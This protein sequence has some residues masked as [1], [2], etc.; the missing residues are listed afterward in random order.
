MP[1]VVTG[2][3]VAVIGLNL[4]PIAV[5]G[6]AGS[7]LRHVD[8]HR[9]DRR[10]GP[11][12]RARAGPRAPAADPARRARR[13]RC[14]T[15]CS[16]TASGSASRSTSP[17]SPA[18]RGSACRTFTAPVWN[19]QAMALIAPVAIVLVAENLGHVKAVAAMTGQNLDPYLGRAFVGD[20]IA[21][22]V[23]GARRRHR[24]HDLRREHRRHGGHEDLLDARVRRRGAHRDRARLLAQVRRADHDDSRPGA[25]RARRS[26]C[27]A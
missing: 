16:P 1:P 7:A 10:R 21:T 11:R 20:G 25:G 4:A 3:V 13:L 2:A 24:R 17:A 22:M 26:S 15:R 6:I 18:P 23:A 8:R 19:A 12:R 5:K 27:S 14:C 9:D